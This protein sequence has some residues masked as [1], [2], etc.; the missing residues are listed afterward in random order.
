MKRI[1]FILGMGLALTG[2]TACNTGNG[3]SNLAQV[4]LA[5]VLD[6]IF[7]GD[8]LSPLAVTYIGDN[9]QPQNAGTISWQSGDPT[10]LTVNPTTGKITALKAGFALVLATARSTTGSALVVVSRALEI[11][12]LLDTLYLM[13]GDTTPIPVQVQH[14]AAGVP[15]V[16]FKTATNAVFD[17]D[18]AGGTASAKA[19]GGPLPFQA[20]AALGPDTVADTGAVR[21]VSLTDTTGGVG[22]YTIH[23]TVVRSVNA[24]AQATNY[25]RIGDTLTFRLRLFIAQG[26]VTAE[27]VLA[28]IRTPL[29]APGALAID[30]ISPT[31][32]L[33]TGFDPVCRPPRSWAS[34][35]TIAT[36]TPLVAL[37]RPAGSITV[38]Q[39][40]PVTGGFAISGRFAFLAQRTDLYDDPLAV[41]PIRGSF[42]APLT[43]STG[44][45]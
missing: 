5:P 18:S 14:Q 9:G 43:T 21:V 25:Q 19:N 28:T 12:L 15:T 1:R 41:L 20:F 30:S 7:V 40:V 33:G 31:E 3:P 26:A 2:G 22:A 10:V 37:S 4:I 34:W 6:S 16:W 42:V 44:R 29:T 13:P 36:A 8:T 35:S 17:V 23:G 38:T 45:C 39:I 27:A 32:A 24:V 11:S